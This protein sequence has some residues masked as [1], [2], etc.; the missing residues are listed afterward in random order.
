MARKEIDILY[1]EVVRHAVYRR[2][3]VFKSARGGLLQPFVA[4]A[5]AVEDDALV[6]FYN[7]AD[8]LVQ[9]RFKIV[10]IFKNVG[11]FAQ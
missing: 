6:L 7:T 10:R 5:V 9:A 2:A 3:E 4:V 11:I 1:I 8:K